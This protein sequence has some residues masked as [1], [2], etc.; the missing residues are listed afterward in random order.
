MKPEQYPTRRLLAVTGLSPQIVTETL[1][2]LAVQQ[3]P[4]FIP[5]EIWLVTT[6]RGAQRA[7]LSLLHADSGW[8][9]RLLA[10]YHL[11]PMQFSPEQVR[12]LCGTDGQPMDDI[13]SPADNTCAA[14]AITEM[15][16]ELTG[17]DCSALHV[18]IAGGRKTMGFYLG[19]ALSLYGRE[20]DRLSHVLV[21]P[22]YESHPEFFYPASR[23]EVIYTPPPDS[24]PYDK[25]DAEVTLADIPFVRMREGLSADLLEGRTSFSASVA[26]AQRALPPVS[27][28]LDP[29]S[30]TV[31]AGGETLTM[32]PNHFSLYW[33]LAERARNGQPGVHWSEQGTGR[34]I[35]GYYGQLVNTASG[36]YEAAEKAY[37]PNEQ[38][39]EQLSPAN[40]DPLKAHI[41]RTLVQR[42]GRRRAGP[43]LI[44]PLTR[45]AGTRYHR[46]GLGLPPETIQIASRKLAEMDHNS[47]LHDHRRQEHS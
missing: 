47:E 30:R 14:D 38:G 40:F 44:K 23:S 27:L 7:R 8:F 39:I 28:A 18:S 22:P 24:A 12:V 26:E 45:M 9:H 31:R 29:A 33:M 25:K 43:Y 4:P 15:V 3:A 41:K 42:L 35:L 1:Y 16:R 11:P 6:Q 34:E 2:A 21:T 5:T 17:D 13:R 20:Q 36:S 32:Q 10:E 37:G 19:Y 46:F